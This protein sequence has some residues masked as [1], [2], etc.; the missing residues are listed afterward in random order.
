MSSKKTILLTGATGF[1]GS[2]LLAA[3]LKESY[4]VV[5]IKRTASDTWRIKHFMNSVISYNVDKQSIEYIFENESINIVIHVATSYSREEQNEL[6]V[7]NTN[8][9]LGVNLLKA[10]TQHGTSLFIN[11]DTFFNVESPMSS[12]MRAYTLSKKQF[13]EW[14]KY[15]S[16]HGVFLVNMKIH[17]LYGA[18]DNNNKF[19]PWLKNNLIVNNKNI[20]LTS[21]IQLR[22]F[23]YIDDAVRAYLFVINNEENKTK[24]KEYIVS[25]GVKTSVRDFCEELYSQINN[26]Y[27][28]DSKLIF[29]AKLTNFNEIIDVEND[30]SSL[31]S[32]GWKYGTTIKQGISEML[33]KE[34]RYID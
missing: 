20:K 14:L 11:T 8:I 25:T 26:K 7:V 15:F 19:I 18:N 5:I 9:L 22:D 31:N 17:H 16:N 12:H 28:T 2:H 10:A 6:D 24:Y 1:L 23:I 34:G 3:L 21:G 4:K 27:G 30:C 32:I 33:K 13:I 29:G